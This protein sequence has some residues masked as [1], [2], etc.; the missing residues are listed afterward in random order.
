V[1]VTAT[2]RPNAFT[3]TDDDG[4]PVGR[5]AL[6]YSPSLRWRAWVVRCACHGR[7]A[8]N[9]KTMDAAVT[10]LSDHVEART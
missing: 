6:A 10:W 4:R 5:V 2:E 3:V 8:A 1:I 7:G 9:L